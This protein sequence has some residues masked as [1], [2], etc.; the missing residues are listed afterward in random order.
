MKD[1]IL[2]LRSEGKSYRQ[3]EALLGCSRSTISYHCS[4]QGVIRKNIN[5]TKHRNRKI[6][7]L[8]EF[9]KTLN[10]GVC[11]EDRWW[12]LDFHHRDSTKK[13]K[14][15]SRMIR[16]DSI[17]KVLIEIEKCDVLCSNCHRDFHYWEKKEV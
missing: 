15:I 7:Y 1:K 4:E 13:E 6:Q 14:S 12:V 8:N 5:I 16:E 11:G 3:I 17:E 10:C 2:K 9:K